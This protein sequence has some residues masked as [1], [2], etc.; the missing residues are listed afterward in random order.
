VFSW[1]VVLPGSQPSVFWRIAEERSYNH[2]RTV[3]HVFE[4][5]YEAL[6]H[7]FANLSGGIS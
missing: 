1:I 4:N 5:P 3:G 2:S 6:P 7:M